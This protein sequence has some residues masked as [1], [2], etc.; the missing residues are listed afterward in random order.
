MRRVRLA[1]LPVVALLLLVAVTLAPSG[2]DPGRPPRAVVLDRTAYACP[3]Q[4]LAVAAGQVLPGT[5]ATARTLPEGEEVADLEDARSWRTTTVDAP[6]V[7]V[8][9]EGDGSGAVGHYSGVTEDEEG[10]GLVVGACGDVV[11]D[12]WFTG[13]GSGGGHQSTLVLTNLAD[14][15]AV[16]DVT[17]WSPEGEVDAVGAAG[18]VVDPFT[19]RS[20]DLDDLAAG[21]AELA[22]QLTRRRGALAVSATDTSTVDPAGSEAPSAAP[23][24]TRRQVVGG[25]VQ[26]EQGRSLHLVNP[27]ASTARVA[28]EVLGQDGAFTPEGLDEVTVDAG[29]AQA[30]DLPRSAGSGRLAVRLTSDQPVVGSVRMASSEDDLAV[31]EAL[32]ALAGPAVVPLD[33]GTDTD[34]PE[35]LLTAVGAPGTARLESFDADGQSLD[36]GGAEIGTDTTVGLDLGDA[37]VIDVEGAAY[38]VVRTSGEVVGSAT[39][40]D[41]DLVAALGLAAAPVTT[42]GPRV[43]PAP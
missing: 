33:L 23:A 27:G 14:G 8:E 16:A 37:D 34:P 6:A 7:L 31:A 22:V 39:Y 3:A 28:V 43:R 32:P 15:P 26:G 5:A 9:Q 10:D 4:D 12:A 20:I 30:V 40:R 25:V 17:L 21:E 13:L 2:S 36:E 1:T 41:G 42:L 18:I 19:T 35:L 11:D 29:T 24:P 38:V